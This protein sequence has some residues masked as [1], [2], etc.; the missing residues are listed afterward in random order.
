MSGWYIDYK[1][2]CE[3][4]NTDTVN[5]GANWT[6]AKTMGFLSLLFGGGGSLFLWFSSCFALT[7]TTWRWAG[8][9]L[10]FA[11]FCQVLTFS[12]FGVDMCHGSDDK[13]K[14]TLGYGSKAD[15]LALVCWLL[16]AAAIFG[17]YPSPKRIGERNN[18][19]L[20]V[21]TE[22]EMVPPIPD[23]EFVLEEQRQTSD[24][25][26]ASSTSERTETI[27]QIS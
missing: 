24:S 4:F 25:D 6:F 5:M 17:K 16:A 27:P 12:W 15:I 11:S 21:P 26:T 8:Y 20:S 2:A 13:D 7:K 22:L 10:L 23:T 1:T 3:D 19:S 14:C 18:D 9:E